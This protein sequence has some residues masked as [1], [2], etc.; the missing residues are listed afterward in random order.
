MIVS[1][2]SMCDSGIGGDVGKGVGADAGDTGL[3]A[4]DAEGDPVVN[5][6]VGA[7]VD[8]GAEAMD[9]AIGVEAVDGVVG[10]DV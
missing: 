4:D 3:G 9:A 5:A 8:A 6:G 1:V 10:A 2:P 7:G